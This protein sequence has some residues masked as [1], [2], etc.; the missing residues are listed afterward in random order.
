MRLL[1]FKGQTTKRDSI[2]PIKPKIT[3]PK[4]IEKPKVAVTPQPQLP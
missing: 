4:S 3:L 1:K 2:T